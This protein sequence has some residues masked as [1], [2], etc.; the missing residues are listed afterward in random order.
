MQLTIIT[1]NILGWVLTCYGVYSL[2]T[3][4]KSIINCTSEEL[5]AGKEVYKTSIFC[6]VIML[7]IMNI[8]LALIK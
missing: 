1:L 7:T 5:N 4:R 8:I 6:G 3:L 2:I